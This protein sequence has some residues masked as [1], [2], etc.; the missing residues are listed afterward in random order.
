M[1]KGRSLSAGALRLLAVGFLVLALYLLSDT[2]Y[3]AYKHAKPLANFEFFLGVLQGV[4]F[5]FCSWYFFDQS[6]KH[7]QKIP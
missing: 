2:A 4:S 3:T 1:N 7:N 5:L 6:R